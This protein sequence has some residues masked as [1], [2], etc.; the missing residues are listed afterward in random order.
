ML[1]NRTKMTLILALLVLL[2]A[3]TALAADPA[4]ILFRE[5]KEANLRD[6]YKRLMTEIRKKARG[7]TGASNIVEI[8][9][10]GNPFFINIDEIA[11]LCRQPCN[12]FQVKQVKR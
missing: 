3:Q 1:L 8:N 12:S 6:G 7:Q 2:S 9:L 4:Y 10:D 11:V 5:G